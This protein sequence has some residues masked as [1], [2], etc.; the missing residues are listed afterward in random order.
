MYT[1][2]EKILTI[3]F[4]TQCI[5]CENEGSDLCEN[6][7][8]SFGIHKPQN[9]DWTISLW[10]YRDPNVEK[11]MRYIKNNPNERIAKILAHE[12]VKKIISERIKTAPFTDI[13]NAVIIPIPIG[14]ARYR[15]RGYNQS[16]LLARPL[17]KTLKRK[18]FTGILIKAKQ[19]K[20]QGTTKS[21]SERLENLKHSF[22]VKFHEKVRHRDVVIVDDIT[23]TGSTLS[24]AR[25]TLLAAGARSV[26][27]VTIAN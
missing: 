23:T 14:R 26:V 22:S 6:C 9:Y 8:M 1:F 21:R 5:I 25:K 12:L 27:A 2:L 20:K 18:L 3:L 10:N 11:L 4:P 7:V 15:S 13:R 24:E 16:L 17:A 19:T